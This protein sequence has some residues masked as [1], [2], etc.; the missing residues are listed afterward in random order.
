MAIS[1]HPPLPHLRFAEYSLLNASG[2]Q[3]LRHGRISETKVSKYKSIS[4]ILRRSNDQVTMVPGQAP[5]I[6][7]EYS[8]DS[9]NRT[10]RARVSLHIQK[11]KPQASIKKKIEKIHKLFDVYHA[12]HKRWG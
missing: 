4:I 5:H 2:N 7:A 12:I 9:R 10:Q 6:T 3:Y 11:P 1:R 8:A